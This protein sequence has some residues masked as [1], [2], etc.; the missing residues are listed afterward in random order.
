MGQLAPALSSLSSSNPALDRI[1]IETSGSAFPATLAMEINRLARETEGRYMLDGVI[2]VIDVE[3]WQ[4]YE[5]TS[6]TAKMQARFTDLVVLNK[7]ESAGERRLDECKDRLGD[8]DLE[9]GIAIVRSEKGRVDKGVL[10][11]LDGRM[12]KEMMGKEDIPDGHRADHHHHHH[13]LQQQQG[14]D[15]HGE[16]HQ[17]EVEVL[18]V[19]LSSMDAVA[20]TARRRG[21]NTKSLETFLRAAPKDEIYRIKAILWASSPPP[22]SSEGETT[23]T[24]TPG[25]AHQ[26]EHPQCYILN[27]AFGRWT[28]TPLNASEG[29]KQKGNSIDDDDGD[30]DGHPKRKDDSAAVVSPLRMTVILARGEADSWKRKIEASGFIEMDGDGDD[31]GRKY[32]LEIKRLL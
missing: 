22:S 31:D 6:Y 7:W 21:I 28:Y 14:G 23:T 10:L 9:S 16:D 26:K 4:G 20:V 3:N 8:L 19:T 12:V 24:S 18:S 25:E 32:R 17:R 27:W 11:G 2:S 5:D 1:V 29:K 13:H 15:H 30:G